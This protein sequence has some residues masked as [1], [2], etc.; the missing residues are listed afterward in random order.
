MINAWAIGMD[1]TYWNESEKFNPERFLDSS[2]DYMGNN[3]EF[4]A[5]GAGKRKCPGMA[6][7]LA[8]V[9]MALAKL[10]YHFDCKLCD[11]VKNEDLDMTEDTGLG[12]YC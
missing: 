5:F 2:I 3:F 10:L 12:K 9:E 7:G 1:P 4:I 6:F 11:G 8:L